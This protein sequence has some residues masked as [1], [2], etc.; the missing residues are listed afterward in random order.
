[1]I[2]K[3][4]ISDFWQ[5]KSK[6][7]NNRNRIIIWLIVVSLCILLF[8]RCGFVQ[9]N[10]Q[11]IPNKLEQLSEQWGDIAIIEEAVVDEDEEFIACAFRDGHERVGV[12]FFQKQK[13]G[14]Y[15]LECSTL[16]PADSVV[17]EQRRVDDEVY[18]AYYSEVPNIAYIEVAEA[19]KTEKHDIDGLTILKKTEEQQINVK[20]YE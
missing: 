14:E 4:Y 13:N 16:Y 11:P 10:K 2:G 18:L 1:M 15:L 3:L 6:K 7:F 17:S 5:V 8:T 20:Y 19:G 12:A 9:Q